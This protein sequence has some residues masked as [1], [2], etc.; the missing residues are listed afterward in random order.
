MS[1]G[2]RNALH[3]GLGVAGMDQIDAVQRNIKKRRL[4]VGCNLRLGQSTWCSKDA[5]RYPRGILPS[6]SLGSGLANRIL[7]SCL[8]KP[9]VRFLLTITGGNYAGRTGFSHRSSS[10][11]PEM[12]AGPWRV[13][14]W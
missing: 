11:S 9:P 8:P 14:S 5:C 2:Y 10:P 6:F 4:L 1:E 12:Q 7:G 13:G 3:R